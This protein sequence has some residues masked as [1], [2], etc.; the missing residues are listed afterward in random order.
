MELLYNKTVHISS[1]FG[2]FDRKISL[3][4]YSSR[5]LPV[6]FPGK[7]KKHALRIYGI[8]AFIIY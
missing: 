8:R 2:K 3:P 1:G 6:R 4:M 7:I 5:I